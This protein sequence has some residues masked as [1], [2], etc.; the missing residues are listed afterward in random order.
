M[1]SMR[2]KNKKL[3]GHA[4]AITAVSIWGV[5]FISTKVLLRE[6]SAVEILVIRFIIGL[7]ALTVVQPVRMK[8][9]ERKQE[10]YYM[11]AGLTG[12]TMYYLLEI[13]A[14]SHTFA[15]N[16]GVIIS[17]APFFTAVVLH[18]FLKEKETF[19]W[20]FFLGFVVALTG[21]VLISFNGASFQLSPVGDL[22]T[23]A[24]AFVWALYSLFLKKINSFGYP[25]ILNTRR[26]F[27]WGLIFMI[28][29]ALSMGFKP[30][31]E[32]MLQP[33][34]LF[35]FL[36]LGVGACAVCFVIWNYAVKVV[37]AVKTSIYIYLDPII[38][39]AVS[40][41]LLHEPVTALM[42][43]GTT[44]TLAGLFISEYKPNKKQKERIFVGKIDNRRK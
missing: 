2:A 33:V 15:S 4:A 12:V 5:T 26:I 27:M 34:Y 17:T 21:I 43:L 19:Y 1:N 29:L 32:K 37:G 3:L 20:T 24:A 8:L 44:L 18:L 13:V 31:V 41:L 11:L 6:F 28:P 7:A 42:T 35:N 14:L 39:V 23:I 22:L 10:L 9:K 16:V 36:F 25:T 40:A 30:A 38:T